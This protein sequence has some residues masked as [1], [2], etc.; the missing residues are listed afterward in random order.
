MK[1]ITLLLAFTLMSVITN[2]QCVPDTSITHNVPGIYP[3]SATGLP[4]SMV[5][6]PYS[7]TI[8]LKVKADTIYLGFTVPIDSVV[9]TNVTGLPAGYSYSCTPSNCSFPGGSDACILLQGPAPTSGMIGSYPIQVQV[10]AHGTVLGSPAS[11]PANINSYSIIIDDSTTGIS[12]IE[13]AAFFV[14]QNT[15]NPTRDLTVIP[16]V[17]NHSDAVTLTVSNLIGK[18]VFAQ[19]YNLQ[20]GKNNINVD[21]HA[22]LPGI[23]LYSISNGKN[24]VTRRMI[25]SND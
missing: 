4:H 3:D 24:T 23:Y 1:I 18:K 15:P 22:L 12:G 14:G 19:S 5:G 2:A 13:K 21:V 7:T 6:F 9:V 16:V 20:K 17:V 10:V 8:Q 11:I 25:I